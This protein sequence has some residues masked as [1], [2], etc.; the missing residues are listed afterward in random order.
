[1][2]TNQ[3]N[4]GNTAPL[5]TDISSKAR[6]SVSTS[7]KITGDIELNK[8]D[9]RKDQH[10]IELAINAVEVRRAVT[11]INTAL[12]KASTSLSFSVDEASKRFIVSVTDS[13][14]GEVIRKLPGEAVL[15]IAKQIDSLKGIIFDQKS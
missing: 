15:R 9:Q 7:P 10:R 6:V 11:E 8:T 1:M 13:A 5:A 14:S 3:L 2:T 4:I 12:E